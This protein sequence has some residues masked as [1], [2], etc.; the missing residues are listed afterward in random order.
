MK[1]LCL[2]TLAAGFALVVAAT[3]AQATTVFSSG[4]EEGPT[5]NIVTFKPTDVDGLGWVASNTDGER[6]QGTVAKP[7]GADDYYASLLQNSGAY[8]GSA[9]G[10]GDFG[11]TGFDRIYATFSVD[12][13]TDYDVSFLHAADDRFGYLGDTSVVEIIDTSTNTTLALETFATPDFFDWTEAGFSFNSGGATSLAIAFTVTGSGNTS[14]VFDEI[15]V[16]EAFAPI[17]IPGGGL[18]LL[19]GLV[20]L[21]ARKARKT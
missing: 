5:T 12:M 6:I 18:L 1:R 20:A 8:D 14:G 19:T 2:G 16:A 15:L 7:A 9:L 17:P 3:A 21:G 13:G 10:V 4:F 11:F